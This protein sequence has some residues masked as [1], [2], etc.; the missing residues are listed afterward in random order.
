M[1]IK[2]GLDNKFAEHF[3]DAIKKL[4]DRLPDYKITELSPLSVI[5]LKTDKSGHVRIIV[6]NC[7]GDNIYESN[8]VTY[9]S[10][11]NFKSRIISFLIAKGYRVV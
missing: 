9:G 1:A 4:E 10:S 7:Y 11:K 6:K 2:S 3:S 8:P 5:A